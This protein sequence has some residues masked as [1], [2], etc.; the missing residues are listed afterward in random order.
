M[1]NIFMMK[2]FFRV[3]LV[4]FLSLFLF[5]NIYFWTDENGTKHFTNISP[6]KDKAV[7]E[8]NESQTIFKKLSSKKN[9]ARLFKVVKVF[10]GDTIKVKGFD[11]TF[12]IRLIGI[13][14]PETGFKNQ[15]AQPYSQR[16]KQHLISL[17]D[18]K[19]VSLKTYG[20]DAYNRQLA[21][22]FEGRK[23]MNL[24]MIKAGLA[25]VYK[26]RRPKNL[27]S[28]TYLKE[29][30]RARQAGKGMWRQ[31]RYYKSPRQWRKE[32]PRK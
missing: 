5:G 16:A 27:D 4:L 9:N 7:E 19:K 24:E 20:T 17:L 26:G 11:L 12:K 10:D 29:E 14:C 13:D 32:N 28:Q 22:V 1:V 6:P 15:Q 23:N 25:E 18:N 30:A 8:Q 31:G 21:E 2:F 3:S